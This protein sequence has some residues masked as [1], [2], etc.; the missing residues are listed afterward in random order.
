MNAITT[1]STSLINDTYQLLVNLNSNQAH[2]RYQSTWH[3]LGNYF[4]VMAQYSQEILACIVP[5]IALMY[6]D[7]IAAAWSLITPGT[8]CAN[9]ILNYSLLTCPWHIGET[10]TLQD[11]LMF[12]YWYGVNYVTY[13]V[14]ELVELLRGGMRALWALRP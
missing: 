4:D 7:F 10:T 13:T 6:S 9:D 3:T 14:P 1:L 8:A 11:D 12:I 2:R 5:L